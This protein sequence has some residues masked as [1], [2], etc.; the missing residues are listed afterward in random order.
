M[1]ANLGVC[2]C[3]L[4]G[5]VFSMAQ[6][7]GQYNISRRCGH[8]TWDDSYRMCV[9]SPGWRIA[10]PTD[11]FAFL[12]GRCSQS[13][14][15]SDSQCTSDLQQGDSQI[16]AH[17]ES[18][19]CMYPGWNCYC[20]WSYAFADSGTGAE[21]GRAKCMGLPYT[22]SASGARAILW[23]IPTSW[24]YFIFV[25]A[26]LLP[27]GQTH[28]RCQHK[29][30]DMGRMLQ[31]LWMP[32]ASADRCRG[33]QRLSGECNGSCT[34]HPVSDWVYT[35]AWSL[36]VIDFMIVFY[37]FLVCLFVLFL[38]VWAVALWL[39][40]I[41]II[42]IASVCAC[43][44]VASSLACGDGAQG[45]C[46]CS[47]DSAPQGCCDSG[48]CCGGQNSWNTDLVLHTNTTD[49]YIGGGAGEDRCRCASCS[50]VQAYV[51]CRP[52]A[53]VIYQFPTAPSNMWG[54]VIGWCMGTNDGGLYA[55][56]NRIVDLLSFRAANDAR[57]NTRWRDSVSQ[58]IYSFSDAPTS[59]YVGME[60]D[61]RA[62][63]L[64][65]SAPVESGH[66]LYGKRLLHSVSFSQEADN[67]VASSYEDYIANTCWI[68]SGCNTNRGDVSAEQ[69]WH[70]WLSCGHMF[71]NQCSTEMS[72]RRMPCPL[73]RRHTNRI[74]E[75]PCSQP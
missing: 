10:G 73:C 29:H 5:P 55:G 50:L 9:C 22:L 51:I 26:L 56:G 27:C 17:G 19:S 49:F 40:V 70:L 24:R 48:D 66:F 3:V 31:F 6:D 16:L 60:A 1:R 33:P 20:G 23:F 25:A 65:S 52:L 63:P 67:I 4:V 75:G 46:C 28:I 18:A 53:W 47:H 13:E 64:L 2:M 12:Q 14:C 72:R 32:F 41:A 7:S 15:Q 37:C 45:D 11:T 71:C 35:F 38:V 21:N 8:G 74:K 62:T 43:L 58:Y 69:Q 61:L 57:D 44:A 59:E 54:G 39:L 42:V 34:R 68:C 36:Y 30:P